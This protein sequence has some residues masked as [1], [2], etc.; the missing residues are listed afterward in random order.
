[1]RLDPIEQRLLQH[2]QKAGCRC[3]ALAAF[4]QVHGPLL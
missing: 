1:M 3:D 2:A 4:G